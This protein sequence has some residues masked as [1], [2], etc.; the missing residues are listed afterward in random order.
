[1]KNDP[2]YIPKRITSKAARYLDLLEHFYKKKPIKKI[3]KMV[4]VSYD[5]VVVWR[6]NAEFKRKEKLAREVALGYRASE[7]ALAREDMAGFFEILETTD[8]RMAAAASVDATWREVEAKIASHTAWQ[9]R[10]ADWEDSWRIR[11]EDLLRKE[12][13][14]G[15]TPSARLY[16]Q[17]YHP[18][19]G[20]GAKG[21]PSKP[22]TTPELSPSD[23]AAAARKARLDIEVGDT[24][25]EADA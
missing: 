9:T 8:D 21:R 16:L 3:A 1:V 4:P 13:K 24:E 17:A 23:R 10:Y 22:E 6:R 14:D 2:D 7:R 5:A 19:Y 15:H 11:A 25:R 12:M 18:R 20:T